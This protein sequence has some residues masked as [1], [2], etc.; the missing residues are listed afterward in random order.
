[1]KFKPKTKLGELSFKFGILYIFLFFLSRILGPL[2]HFKDI[3]L[4]ITLTIIIAITSLVS[5]LI[6]S[7]LGIRSIIKYKERSIFVYIFSFMG[8]LILFVLIGELI[9]SR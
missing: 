4:N 6:S 9:F 3:S 1:M 7:F 2:F 8:I 5:G